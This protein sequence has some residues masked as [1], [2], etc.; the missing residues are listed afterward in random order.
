MGACGVGFYRSALGFSSLKRSS[1]TS[2]DLAAPSPSGA[3]SVSR[4]FRGT[5]S[6]ASYVC[7]SP[8]K[9]TMAASAPE[10][11]SACVMAYPSLQSSPTPPVSHRTGENQ[12]LEMGGLEVTTNPLAAP[13]ITA[14]F[15]SREKLGNVRL[16]PRAGLVGIPLPPGYSC[17]MLGSLRANCPGSGSSL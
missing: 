16:K 7:Y 9:S 11:T 5:G 1:R 2:A 12:T 15:P 6:G 13:V 10:S 17:V 3:H 4:G 8:S 14:T